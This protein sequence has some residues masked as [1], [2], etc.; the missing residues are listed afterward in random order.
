M[1]LSFQRP[2]KST[3]LILTEY[4]ETFL[5]NIFPRPV[6][7][8]KLHLDVKCSNLSIFKTF[9]AVCDDQNEKKI[10]EPTENV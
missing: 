1:F 3:Y 6:Y 10:T 2:Q 9:E 5:D 4:Q 8:F 7:Y